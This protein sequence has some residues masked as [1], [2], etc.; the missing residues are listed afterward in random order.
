MLS[1]VSFRL[2]IVGLLLFILL[3]LIITSGMLIRKFNEDRKQAIGLSQSAEVIEGISNLIHEIQKERAR[4]VLFLNKVIGEPELLEQRKK[5]DAMTVAAHQLF[6]KILDADII[7]LQKNANENLIKLRLEVDKQIPAQEFTPV[8]SK[9]IDSWIDLQKRNAQLY[10]LNGLE[11][12]LISISIFEKSIESM[13]RMRAMLNG[14]L[15]QDKAISGIQVS[16]LATNRTGVL[17]NMDS[18][19]LNISNESRNQVTS[20]LASPEWTLVLE[21]YEKL[22]E[23]SSTGGYGVDAKSTSET[24]TKVIDSVKKIIDDEIKRTQDVILQAE[25]N[26]KNGFMYS[27]LSVAIIILV[28]VTWSFVFTTNVNKSLSTISTELEDGAAV[29]SQIANKISEAS[30]SLSAS[31][32][33]QAAAL[34]ETTVATEET[35]EIINKNAE[36]AKL[37]A[38]VSE[39]SQSTATKGKIEVDQMIVAIGEIA[40]NN[41]LIMQQMENSNKELVEI[42]KVISDIGDKTKVINEIVFQTKLLS[43]NASVEAA[44][45]GEN[46]KGFAVVAEEVGNLAQMSGNASQEITQMLSNSIQKVEEIL[47]STQISA[48]ELLESGRKKVEVGTS[49][50]KRCGVVLDE[51][52]QNTTKVS[53]LVANISSASQE[54][55]KGV[56]EINKAVREIDVAAQQNNTTAQQASVSSE[57]LRSQ[58]EY[59]NKM[60]HNLNAVVQGQAKV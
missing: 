57:E 22:I 42:V 44:R 4:T 56:S 55:A 49:V 6:E 26:S 21:I 46:G 17:V 33:E 12:N 29:I 1:R 41:H 40:Q 43:F 24:I 31:S 45:A 19:G 9:I 7:K 20:V 23:K 52:V 10:H 15:S 47:K 59:L 16:Q 5:V 28:S 8:I 35:S 32:T 34:Q 54:Q 11:A 2:K 60:V 51:I 38:E 18:P 58:V 39:I 14:I 30:Q 25:K 37:S 27:L 36:N 53:H 50:A 3:G 13:G 48:K